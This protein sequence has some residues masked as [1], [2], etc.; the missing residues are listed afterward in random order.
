M[1]QRHHIISQRVIKNTQRDLGHGMNRSNGPSIQMTPKDHRMTKSWGGGSQAKAYRDHQE[2][3]LRDGKYDEAF[4]EEYDF[5]K[6]TFGD[7]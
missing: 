6:T 3:L 7:N 2:K 4:K 5:I 1:Y